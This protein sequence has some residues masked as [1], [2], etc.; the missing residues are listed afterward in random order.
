MMKRITEMI[1]KKDFGEKAKKQ[2]KKKKRDIKIKN[3]G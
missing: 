3:N 2:N 1:I